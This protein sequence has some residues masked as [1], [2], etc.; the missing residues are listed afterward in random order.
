VL[1]H[2]SDIEKGDV[3]SMPGLVDA[4][5]NEI[6][7]QL[8]EEFAGAFAGAAERAMGTTRNQGAIDALTRRLSGLDAPQQ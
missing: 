2:T 8:P 3:A 5:R 4:T 6:A 7:G 1:I